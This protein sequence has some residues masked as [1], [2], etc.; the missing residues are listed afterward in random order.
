MKNRLQRRVAA[1]IAKLNVDLDAENKQVS[2]PRQ[3]L[4][5]AK[6]EKGRLQVKK[7]VRLE[8]IVKSELGEAE[9][10][11]RQAR[12]TFD[13]AG[14]ATEMAMTSANASRQGTQSGS[15]HFYL[16]F[17]LCHIPPS[18]PRAILTPMSTQS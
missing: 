15:N 14:I 12:D 10:Q 2:K 13:Q 17:E 1:R 16:G 11:V 7:K 18:P 4:E 5:I 8:A 9:E 3:D 6:A